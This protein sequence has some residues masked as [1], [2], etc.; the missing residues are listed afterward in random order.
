MSSTFGVQLFLCGSIFRFWYVCV[1]ALLCYCLS[2]HAC[3][4]NVSTPEQPQAT[5]TPALVRTHTHTQKIF[6]RAAEVGLGGTG[7]LFAEAP[8]TTDTRAS[9]VEFSVTLVADLPFIQQS[10]LLKWLV[11]L[12]TAF[13]NGPLIVRRLRVRSLRD[14]DRRWILCLSFQFVICFLSAMQHSHECANY[15]VAKPAR[16][17]FSF[18]RLCIVF[19]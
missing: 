1:C 14:Y 8:S 7:Q 9:K 17:F 3:A 16:A 5:H 11:G 19:L 13:A 2:L 4:C 6:M 12:A 18:K 15:S 10:P